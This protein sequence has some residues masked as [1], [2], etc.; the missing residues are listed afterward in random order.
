VGR[1]A[2]PRVAAVQGPGEDAGNGVADAAVAAEDLAV[3]DA[4]LATI[5]REFPAG[6]G[7]LILGI[8][9]FVKWAS[10]PVAF[11]L[12]HLTV[13]QQPVAIQRGSYENGMPSSGGYTAPSGSLTQLL[14]SDHTM[15]EALMTFAS[16]GDRNA[17]KVTVFKAAEGGNLAAELILAEQ[18]NSR[19]VHFRTKSGCT[20]LW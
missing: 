18:Y 2:A 3:G 8:M 1:T 6:F 12:S 14:E 15:S 13:S 4:V 9:A 10:L 20:A 5:S 17:Y 16:S 7:S 11:A 19:T